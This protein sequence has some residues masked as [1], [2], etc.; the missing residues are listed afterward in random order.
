M[1]HVHVHLGRE[2]LGLALG[3]GVG[4]GT[5][6]LDGDDT[7]KGTGLVVVGNLDKAGVGLAVDGA[8]AGSASGDAEGDLEVHVD[9]GGARRDQAAALEQVAEVALLGDALGAV[10]VV[11]GDVGGRGELSAAGE[12]TR[13]RGVDDGA[14]GPTA[15]GGDD[16]EGG[17]E[18]GGDLGQGGAGQGHGLREVVDLVLAA[19]RGRA[20]AVGGQLGRAE[21]G[22]VDLGLGVGARAWHDGALD[23][24]RGA[25]ATGV[26]DDSGDLAVGGDEGRGG[27]REDKS[28]GEHLDLFGGGGGK[29][30]RSGVNVL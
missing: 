23:A 21:D 26:T 5:G 3:S 12:L 8:R 20:Q 4:A 6:H 25:V 24:E 28:L 19:A 2:D 27:E 18:V 29:V 22:G 13:A 15:V 14:D 7:T 16:V 10:A 11:A 30:K 17:A 9:V 1:S